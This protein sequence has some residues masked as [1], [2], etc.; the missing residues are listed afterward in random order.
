M[1]HLNCLC[2][3]L[4]V[5]RFQLNPHIRCLDYLVHI[6]QLFQSWHTQRDICWRIPSIMKCI[7]R[8][9]S[10]GFSHGLCSH[11][12]HHLARVNNC[13]QETLFNLTNHPFKCIFCNPVEQNNLLGRQHI[14]QMYIKELSCIFL[15][16][17][18]D[19]T[20]LFFLGN[21]YHLLFE[22]F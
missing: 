13:L 21:D 10:S 18:L 17:S 9:L 15:G 19:F 5:L 14:W 8:H 2:I 6:N 11:A 22:F 20:P 16:L 3:R 12:A 4:R 7:K 1:Q